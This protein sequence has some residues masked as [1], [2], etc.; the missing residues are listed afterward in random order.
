HVSVSF[1]AFFADSAA[2]YFGGEL[3]APFR[4]GLRL[5][6]SLLVSRLRGEQEDGIGGI[7]EHR[8]REDDVLVDPKGNPGQRLAD[9]VR[10]WQGLEEVASG[11]VQYVEAVRMGRV[12]H[13]DCG[14]AVRCWRAEPPYSLEAGRVLV[15]HGKSESEVLRVRAHL[16]TSLDA[17][18]PSDRHETALGPSDDPAC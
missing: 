11:H 9:I 10:L 3:H 15:V 14:H 7:H 16:G 6:S 5:A 18:M 17:A 12:N 2:Q 1:G 8:A 13:P 4:V